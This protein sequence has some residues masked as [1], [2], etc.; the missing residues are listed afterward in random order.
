[1][2][3]D[4]V[5][6]KIGGEWMESSLLTGRASISHQKG[7]VRERCRTKVRYGSTLVWL[8][9]CVW[10]TISRDCGQ[11]TAFCF[12]AVAENGRNRGQTVNGIGNDFETER[13]RL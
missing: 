7:D 1:M 6:F 9:C 3:T 2:T 10:M 11:E 8:S 13:N 12:G 4:G 5:S